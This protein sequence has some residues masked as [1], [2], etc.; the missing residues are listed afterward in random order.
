[1]VHCMAGWVYVSL[2]SVRILSP[3][4]KP[5]L[6]CDA[7]IVSPS[8]VVAAFPSRYLYRCCFSTLLS[9]IYSGRFFFYDFDD[10][11]VESLPS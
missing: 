4:F 7:G 8:R 11:A 6:P 2:E 10:L 9:R 1:M 5:S 3:C